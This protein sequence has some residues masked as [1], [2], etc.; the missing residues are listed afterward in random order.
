[1]A[2]NTEIN[3]VLADK[4]FA[5]YGNAETAMLDKLA[6]GAKGWAEK[7]GPQVSAL[8]KDLKAIASD[9]E[10]LAKTQIDGT[11]KKAYKTGVASVET[12]FALKKSIMSQIAVPRSIKNLILE[13]ENMITRMGM[14]SL[15]ST[16]DVYHQI[17]AEIA[18]GILTGVDT[19]MQATQRMLNRFADRGVTGFVDKAGRKWDLAS[20]AEMA[21]R[22]VSGNAML[23]GHVD[24]QLE[25]GRDLV[26]V[27][28]HGGSCP[29]C[30][31][32]AGRVLSISGKTPGYTSLANARGAGLFHPNCRH[33]VT[34]YI[35][36]LSKP[37]K[38]YPH[39]PEQYQYEQ[40]QRANERAIRHW[41]KREV[42]AITP[43]A[44][45]Q[46][47]GKVL[48]YQAR[49]RELLKDYEGKFG[50]TVPRKYSRESILNRQ[51]I[52]GGEKGVLWTDIKPIKIPRKPRTPK[53]KFDPKTFK[54]L[55]ESGNSSVLAKNLARHRAHIQAIDYDNR[56][57][58]TIYTGSEYKDINDSLRRGGTH[59]ERVPV[60]T[61]TLEN[62]P[63]LET[64]TK[65][66]RNV[67][68]TAMKYL[69][70]DKAG[71]LSIG[72]AN[73]GKPE[74]ISELKKL[75]V[76]GTF[77][78]DAFLSTT[79]KEGAFKD[80]GVQFEFHL[81]K[82]YDKGMFVESISN[83]GHEKEFLLQR[84]QKFE[85]FDVEVRNEGYMYLTRLMV[86]EMKK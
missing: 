73:F 2:I 42:V 55:T 6:R 22:T 1:M 59:H 10:K 33:S 46:A 28:D 41:K 85:I 43:Q 32:W 8:T 77:T 40:R 3:K 31:P 76:N 79:Y 56:R 54:V 70:N 5:I 83:F 82:G 44:Q 37:G 71:E 30:A 47:K 61:E 63:E 72:I 58:L 19:R 75:L 24:R 66:F 62:C 18:P 60:L 51:G 69:F 26:L 45:M 13:Q 34:G 21:T 64:D 81:K 9:A 84:G 86:R 65:V 20:Y 38:T 4:I 48:A 53:E 49:Q 78:D 16:V 36:G 39:D 15:R 27:S 80:G 68:L 67:D 14:R 35:E 57:S 7:K 74:Q 50:M 12:D 11:I 52:P 17:Q 29:I 23:Q 25:A